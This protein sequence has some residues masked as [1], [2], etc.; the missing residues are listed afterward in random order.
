[1]RCDLFTVAESTSIDV[2]TNRLSVFNIFDEINTPSLPTIMPGL[3]VVIMLTRDE[4]EPDD[5]EIQISVSL[6]GRPLAQLP[7][8]SSFQSKLKARIVATVQGMIFT[9]QGMYEL[10]GHRGDERLGA[11][12]LQVNLIPTTAQPQ[13]QAVETVPVSSPR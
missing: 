13:I 6:N 9:E 4:S 5:V 1:M 12:N 7:V 3:A 11:W 10:A 2:T 8:T